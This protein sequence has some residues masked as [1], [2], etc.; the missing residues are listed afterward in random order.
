MEAR[1]SSKNQFLGDPSGRRRP[2]EASLQATRA[3]R[4]LV[5]LVQSIARRCF[6]K[7]RV[8]G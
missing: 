3:Y 7:R 2:P 8:V 5:S 6:G 1:P 4:C